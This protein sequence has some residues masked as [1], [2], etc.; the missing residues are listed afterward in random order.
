MAGFGFA[1]VAE[2]AVEGGFP[3]FQGLQRE[4]GA[5]DVEAAGGKSA[6]GGDVPGIGFAADGFEAEGGFAAEE[7][8]GGGDDLAR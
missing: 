6:P 5:A 8:A 7:A 1:G 2:T 4:R 3:G